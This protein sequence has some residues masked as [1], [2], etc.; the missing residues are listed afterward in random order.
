MYQ[1]LLGISS[2]GRESVSGDP[3]FLLAHWLLAPLEVALLE[4]PVNTDGHAVRDLERS[5]VITSEDISMLHIGLTPLAMLV[6]SWRPTSPRV[7]ATT[8]RLRPKTKRNGLTS[9][10][11]TVMHNRV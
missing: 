8:S 11:I 6:T 3:W 9:T 5:G 1:C 4:T 10:P 2:L 7:A